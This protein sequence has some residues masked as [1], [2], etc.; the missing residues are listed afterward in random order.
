MTPTLISRTEASATPLSPG[1]L[2]ALM[3]THGTALVCAQGHRPPD[4]A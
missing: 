3:A 4:A 1:R 2:S